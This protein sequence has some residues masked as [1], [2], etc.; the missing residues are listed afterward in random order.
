MR[1]ALL[2]AA[3]LV[4]VSASADLPRGEWRVSCPIV[5]P[6][7][8][9]PGLVYLPLDAEALAGVESRSEYRIADAN[10]AETPYR[11]VVEEGR[12][13]VRPV[14]VKLV[15]QAT[16]KAGLIQAVL[17]LG[18]DSQLANVL[19]LKLEGNNF[20]ARVV[21]N[22][23][24]EES[25]PGLRLG[26]GLVYRHEGKFEQMRVAIPPHGQR[27]LR[28]TVTNLQGKAPKLAGVVA[29]GE[30]WIPRKLVE[31][32]A[33]LTRREDAEKHV[34]V[35]DLDMGVLTWNL[36]EARFEVEEK[37]FDR[38]MTALSSAAKS[39]TEDSYAWGECGGLRRVV[40]GR[41]VVALLNTQ[42]AR[43]LRLTVANGDDR[44]LGIS[45]VKLWRVR[46]G[47]V[48]SAS[49]GA[50]YELWYGRRGA[51]QPVYD[52]QRLPLT[53]P[54]AKLAQATLGAPHQMP[55]K[56]PP[57]PPWSERHPAYF[58]VVLIAV[59]ALLLLVIV[60]AIRGAKQAGARSI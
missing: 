13:E 44:P 14:P 37:T 19:R 1:A 54:P 33:K 35:L 9:A 15:S 6:A 41:P 16:G 60:K 25:Q 28:L 58:W 39:P 8:K 50:S 55:L 11:M 27:Y 18:S 34:T 57:P 2:L 51:A 23:A 38:P 7:L 29:A 56:P 40:A 24:D 26:E 42:P 59:L 43:W 3:V 17:D 49:P 10:Q 45:S 53:I 31:A 30:T 47:L 52:I 32:P 5:L 12:S 48:F 21:M 20:R 36:A 4:A 22:G 46:Q